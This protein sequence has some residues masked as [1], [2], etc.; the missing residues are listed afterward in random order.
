VITEVYELVTE[1]GTESIKVVT[2]D[3][4]VTVYFYTDGEETGGPN[5][6]EA[7]SQR[8]REYLQGYRHDGYRLVSTQEEE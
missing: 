5:I 2:I 7:G 4:E 6:Y 1:E 3:D 8:L